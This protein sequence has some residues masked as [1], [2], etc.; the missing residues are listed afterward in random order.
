[1]Q[2]CRRHPWRHLSV[3]K[4][5]RPNSHRLAVQLPRIHGAKLTATDCDFGAAP[6]AL[7]RHLVECQH[8]H[9]RPTAA[10]TT[11]TATSG[12]S[13]HLRRLS[14][15]GPVGTDLHRRLTT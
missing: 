2:T 12:C 5:F 7:P 14:F 11:T 8:A 13:C 9:R 1:M 3:A 6:V 4:H 10:S 15:V